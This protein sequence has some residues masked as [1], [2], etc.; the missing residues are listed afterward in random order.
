V[1]FPVTGGPA[2]ASHR[3]TTQSTYE[4]L[5]AW[6]AGLTP[7]YLEGALARALQLAQ[8]PPVVSQL[9]RAE[10]EAL[11]DAERLDAAAEIDRAKADV[12]EA[13]A[14]MARD[15]AERIRRERL[16]TEGALAATD[17]AAAT[18]EADV[19][20]QAARDAR[21]SAAEAGRRRHEAQTEAARITSA[22]QRSAKTR[23]S[24]KKK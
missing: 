19:H 1:F 18:L 2:I 24:G 23:R 7:V 12:D 5:V 16:A 4:M 21:A 8:Q 14:A 9:A 20:E 3:E 6:A 15:D 10:F 22:G 17:E 11:Q 13:A